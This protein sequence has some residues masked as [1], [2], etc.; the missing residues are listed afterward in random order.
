MAEHKYEG[1]L[2][3]DKEIGPT[4]HDVIA[5]LRSIVGMRRIG[6]CGTLDPLASGILLVCLGSFTRLNEWLSAGEKEY[7]STFFLGATSDTCDA[8]GHITP[9]QNITIPAEDEVIRQVRSF[10]GTI[11][12]VPPAFSALKVQ[13]VRSYKLARRNLAVPLK[14]RKVHIRDIDVLHYDFPLVTLRITCSRG[15]Y[16]RSLAADLGVRLGCGGYVQALRRCRVGKLGLDRALSLEQ[17]REVVRSGKLTQHFV[18]PHNALDDLGEAVLD[19]LQLSSFVHGNPV[20]IKPDFAVPDK[21]VCAVYDSDKHLYGIGQWESIEGA[22]KP[23]RVL[24]QLDPGFKTNTANG[25]SRINWKARAVS[26]IRFSGVVECGQ[27]RG[28]ELGFPTAN[29]K[30]DSSA[31]SLE[32]GVYVGQVIWEGGASYDALINFGLRPTFAEEEMSLELHVLD[33]SGD[34]Y[35]KTIDVTILTRLRDE[36]RFNGREELIQQIKSD[37]KQARAVLGNVSDRSKEEMED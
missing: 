3:V 17:V 28:R 33:F 4:S 8:Q 15:T 22:L 20:S 37:V 21:M 10:A 19:P 6:H 30:V 14:A 11:E 29:L 18:A 27:G 13:G 16:I 34:L 9:G 12:Q 24:R 25:Q 7:E 31:L 1:I 5:S 32:R 36:R 2:V 23:V 26:P 35:G